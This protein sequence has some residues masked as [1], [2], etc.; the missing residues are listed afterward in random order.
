MLTPRGV[1]GAGVAVDTA[2]A[3]LRHLHLLDSAL[4][5]L[6]RTGAF[7]PQR[8]TADVRFTIG[9]RLE[10]CRFG[11]CVAYGWDLQNL[12]TEPA[13]VERL[14]AAGGASGIV[15]GHL[16]PLLRDGHRLAVPEGGRCLK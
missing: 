8:R 9:Q 14:E 4:T 5:D 16:A 11:P 6:E 1:P 10:H 3:A 2:L 7:V 12:C 15:D 13:S